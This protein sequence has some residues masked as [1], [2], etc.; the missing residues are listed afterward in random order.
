MSF[1]DTSFSKALVALLFSEENH[2][3]NFGR[4]HKKEQFFEIT[5]N[6][7]QWFRRRCRLKTFLSYRSGAPLFS[8][9]KPFV[10]FW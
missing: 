2:L 7:A 4:G 1:K 10:H 5:L 9:A 3:C 6:L 8:E